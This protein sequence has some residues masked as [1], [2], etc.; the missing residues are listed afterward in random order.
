ML[1]VVLFVCY[2][3]LYLLLHKVKFALLVYSSVSFY[4]CLELGKHNQDTEQ[5]HQASRNSF[6]DQPTCPYPY[7]ELQIFYVSIGL[8]SPEPH[9]KCS[10][11]SLSSLLNI[12]HLRF[13]H[14][15][16]YISNL[17]FYCRVVLHYKDVSPVCFSNP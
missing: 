4:Q 9:R 12:I 15:D 14:V 2:S 6:W 17:F 13:I 7:L 1:N 8:F 10:L 5:L 3:K 11:L 16:S